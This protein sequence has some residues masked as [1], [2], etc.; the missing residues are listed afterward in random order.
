MIHYKLILNTGDN[1]HTKNRL[2]QPQ[3]NFIYI[4]GILHISIHQ[5]RRINKRH[6]AEAL[7]TRRAD[8]RAQILGN[9]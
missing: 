5:P 6:Q 7:L 4:K 3:E 2:T 8:L 1:N 9:T